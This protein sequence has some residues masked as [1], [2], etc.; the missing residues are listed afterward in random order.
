MLVFYL[1][2]NFLGIDRLVAL[3]WMDAI[4]LRGIAVAISEN[5]L[6]LDAQGN[7]EMVG[8]KKLTIEF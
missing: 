5:R 8:P 3:G 6:R 1:I 7:R 4:S 2:V